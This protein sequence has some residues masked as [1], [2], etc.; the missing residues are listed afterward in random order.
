MPL[1]PDSKIYTVSQLN[2]ESKR[3]LNEHFFSVRVEGEISNLSTPSSG[4][5]YF[6]LKDN[7][8]QIRCAMFKTQL[9]RLMFNPA[10]GLQIIATAQV[11]LYE[12][13]G[14]YQLVVENLEEAGDGALRMAFEA[15]KRQ[16]SV[17]G[18]FDAS[19]K[20]TL[21]TLPHCIGVIT[22]PSGAAIRDILTVLKRRF[23]AVPV[24][25]YPVAVQG[26][27]AKHDIVRALNLANTLGQCDVLI[28][29]RG[30]G[31]LEDLQ[32]FNEEIVARAIDASAIPVI[33]GIGHE[34]DVTIADFVADLRAATPSAA[35]EHAVPDQREWQSRFSSLETK[36]SQHLGRQLTQKA[37]ALAWLD[38]RL[39]RQHPGQKLAANAQ[40]LDELELRL[41][42]STNRKLLQCRSNLDT[43]TAKL[44][45]QS[46]AHK[47]NSHR[48][49]QHNLQQRLNTAWQRKFEHLHQRLN[50]AGQT[51]HA[52]SPLATMNRGYALVTDMETG[53]VIRSTRQ[54]KKD[55]VVLTRLAN[56]GFTSRVETI[57]ED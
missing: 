28:L 38:K 16:L 14:D 10:N 8:A 5:I 13:R 34:I 26:D 52:V 30:G 21:P 20:Q 23:P 3:V 41:S 18:L 46:P 39:N 6:S 43:Q 27:S 49:R 56:G 45:S 55:D 11:T 54:I 29:G 37:Q 44:Y 48:L 50:Q 1:T 47:I 40:R 32:A 2:R 36:L 4:H 7:A 15:L 24:I 17:E 33:A 51:L 22:S 35:A 12:P 9:R 25:L 31:S 53:A 19:R 42:R 57:T